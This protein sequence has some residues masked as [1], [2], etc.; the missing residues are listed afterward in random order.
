METKKVQI[1]FDKGIVRSLTNGNHGE[2]E[3]CVN[4]IYKDGGLR[5]VQLGRKWTN[6]DWSAIEN[7]TLFTTS[8]G[9][10][11]WVGFIN[12]VNSGVGHG[13]LFEFDPKVP[14]TNSWIMNFAEGETLIDIKSLKNYLIVSTSEKLYTFLCSNNEYGMCDYTAID[15]HITPSIDIQSYDGKELKAFDFAEDGQGGTTHN[16]LYDDNN[17][18][19]AEELK[20]FI[21]K[22]INEESADNGRLAG[23]VSWVAALRLTNGTYMMQTL[24]TIQ[25]E[26][27]HY[28]WEVVP[29]YEGGSI[30]ATMYVNKWKGVIN[31]SDYSSLVDLDMIVSSLCIF[32]SKP[33]TQF[34]IEKT[35]TN[36][37]IG[38]V[39]YGSITF[40]S[41]DKISEDWENIASPKLGW[42][43][44]AEIPISDILAER[45]KSITSFDCSNYFKLDNFYQNYATREALPVDQL[46]HHS[47]A[48]T[49]MFNYNSRL[50]C[51]GFKRKLV[52]PKVIEATN[53][54]AGIGWSAVSLT[55]RYVVRLHVD[56]D[57]R[58]V[59][60]D[61]FS[62]DCAFDGNS[63]YMFAF[64]LIGYPDQRAYEVDIHVQISGVWKLLFTA[65]LKSSSTHNFSSYFD[66]DNFE[67]GLNGLIGWGKTIDITSCSTVSDT[68]TV[69]D[70][71]DSNAS[72]VQLSELN[73]PL[74]FPSTHNY[75]VSSG[76]VNYFAVQQNAISEGQFGQF[77]V[78][79]AT[80][81]GWYALQLGNNEVVVSASIP[82]CKDI[83]ISEPLNTNMGIFYA[84]D[85]KIKCL[86]DRTPLEISKPLR[87]RAKTSITTSDAYFSAYSNNA[88]V[89]T[90]G[91]ILTDY[92]SIESFLNAQIKMSYDQ[93]NNRILVSN[94]QYGFSYAFDMDVKHWYRISEGFN[95]FVQGKNNLFGINQRGI[96]WIDDPVKQTSIDTH[97]HS[98]IL[99]LNSLNR[100]KIESLIL[101]CNLKVDSYVALIL[102]ASN[103]GEKWQMITGNDRLSN[104][105]SE[106]RL[107]QS[108]ASYKFFLLAFWGTIWSGYD[109]YIEGFESVISEKYRKI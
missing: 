23:C 48:L 36:D 104:E 17:Y 4:M 80:S 102:F 91:T 61:E 103:D 92:V 107:T 45:S 1:A 94:A 34:D 77:P 46:T 26:E 98:N 79:C 29:G 105:I 90:L 109:N 89:C 60:S 81:V 62:I 25:E 50:W 37:F 87:G 83:A 24:P 95:Y 32:F 74:V 43:K 55:C 52:K 51:A 99:T 64:P 10:D 84:T 16:P 56:N 93:I 100:K 33:F 71:D 58:S 101:S 21:Y 13:Y 53:N 82:V 35:I 86:V 47:P 108:F 7:I 73:N 49:K 96:I 69:N 68:I 9:S 15:L 18:D 85:T 44:V 54:L 12:A 3:D 72:Q 14:Q 65:Q 67:F 38:P 40:I 88:Q 27:S 57:K 76:R 41:G 8:D 2:L 11:H 66:V 20:S 28:V 78:M 106:V 97:F 63:T 5:P 6:N 70:V 59:I 42:F 30:N 75:V 19:C 22:K 31:T 39:P